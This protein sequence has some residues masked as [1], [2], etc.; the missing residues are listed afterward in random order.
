[1]P[2]LPGLAG[3][4]DTAR[5]E[6]EEGLAATPATRINPWL[7]GHLRRW[8][9]LAGGPTETTSDDPVTPYELEISGDWQ[10][11]VDAWRA[12]GCL[13]DTA[14]AQLGGDV[15]AVQAAL[16]TFRQLGAKAA[17]RRARQRLTALRGPTRGSRH[18]KVPADPHGL[19]GR[20]REVLELLTAGRTNAE[21][22]AT[23]YISRKTVGHHVSA[24][25]TKLGVENRTHAAAQALQRPPTTEA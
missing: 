1:V 10:A 24:I 16:A 21:I 9:H 12:R 5:T 22:A 14:L 8:V 18:A 13:Y 6:A 3:D 15:D 4:D 17:A 11:A 2:K 23:L 19:T 25:I 7:V 20:E